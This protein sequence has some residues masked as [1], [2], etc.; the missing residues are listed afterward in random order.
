MFIQL[1]CNYNVVVYCAL[2]NKC[3]IHPYCDSFQP[4]QYIGRP[5]K[6][7]LLRKTDHL[8]NFSFYTSIDKTQVH[9]GT[10]IQEIL[11]IFSERKTNKTAILIASMD[12][13]FHGY[14]YNIDTGT[15]DTT[16]L[17]NLCG[18]I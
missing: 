4:I 18:P 9:T 15:G 3:N 7:Y 5:S 16:F 13:K 2:S 12:L 11:P 14:G 6:N 17:K 1:F 10:P 8:Q